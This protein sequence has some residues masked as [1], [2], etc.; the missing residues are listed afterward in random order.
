MVFLLLTSLSPNLSV[1]FHLPLVSFCPAAS[2]FCCLTLK[3]GGITWDEWTRF[4]SKLIFPTNPFDFSERDTYTPRST[5]P[6]VSALETCKP[7]KPGI[8][9]RLNGYTY[10]NTKKIRQAI[11]VS[12]Q[13][14]VFVRWN[15]NTTTSSINTW[16]RRYMS[17]YGQS[18]TF[19]E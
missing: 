14:T 7:L 16:N 6:K 13:L 18:N 1:S 15:L 12:N 8:A 19:I 3:L 17:S 4:T 9:R 2:T 11:A 5:A 10:Q